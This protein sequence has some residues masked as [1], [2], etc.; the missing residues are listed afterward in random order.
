MTQKCEH[1]L[2]AILAYTGATPA[3]VTS[4]I[5]AGTLYVTGPHDRPKA[6]HVALDAWLWRRFLLR[7]RS[8]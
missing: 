2:T 6:T 4:A 8:A 7:H 5:G 1:G 3:E